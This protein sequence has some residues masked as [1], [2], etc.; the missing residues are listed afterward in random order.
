M[1]GS[2][3]STVSVQQHIITAAQHDM[4][5]IRRG[6]MRDMASHVMHPT[7]VNGKMEMPVWMCSMYHNLQQALRSCCS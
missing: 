1:N 5:R 2:T 6:A 4:H 7:L 3:G